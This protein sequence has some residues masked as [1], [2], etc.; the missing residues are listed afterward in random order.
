V[1]VGLALRRV[2][3]EIKINLLT[4][5]RKT[6]RRSSVRSVPELTLSCGLILVGAVLLVGWRYWSL[7]RDAAR[8]TSGIASAE[9][10][11]RGPALHDRAGAAIRAR[12]TSFSSASR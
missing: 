1:A 3:I 12:K 8:L 7:N 11:L 10:E 9:K 5:E 4:A 2:G 6:S